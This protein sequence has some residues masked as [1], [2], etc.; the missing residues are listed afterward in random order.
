MKSGHLSQYF[1]G[2]ASKR[3]RKVEVDPKTSNQHEFDGINP[4]R[5]I[6]GETTDT[7]RFPARFLFLADEQDEP[8]VADATVSWYDSR[9]AQEHRSAEY[10]L[11]FPSSPVMEMAQ[12]G[13]LLLVAKRRDGSLLIIVTQASSTVENQVRSLFGIG[14][15]ARGC[16]VQTESDI[17]RIHLDFVARLILDQIGIESRD[18]DQD[19][20]EPMLSRFS[21]TFPPTRVF[22]QYARDSLPEWSPAGDPDAIIIAW[23]EREEMLFRTLEKHIVGQ[24]LERGFS[25]NV[26]EFVEFS[27]S[28]HNRRKSR[29]GH[30]LEN[31]LEAIFAA[32]NV[33]YSRQQVTENRAKP[34]FLFP[35]VKEYHNPRFPVAR[36]S[37]LGVK[38]TCKDRWRQILAEARRIR[39]K[40]LFTFEPAISVNQT[41]EMHSHRVHLVIPK[42][43]QDSFSAGQRRSL[44]SLEDFLDLVLRRQNG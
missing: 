40:H 23:M 22:S 33:R 6:L 31:H 2:V 12:P 19:F 36:L 4:L 43:V 30:A 41:R 29:V 11:Y 39:D 24:R 26:D 3:L 35:G 38:S 28:V 10:R 34:D 14:H 1:S 15:D 32:R 44:L 16:R 21:G 7:R 18:V 8:P 42:R 27:L 5:A 13:D 20:L 37:V 9:K 25:E 17:E